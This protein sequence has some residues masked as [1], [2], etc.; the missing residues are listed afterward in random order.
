M[1]ITYSGRVTS[2]DGDSPTPARF[3][4]TA[5]VAVFTV[6][7]R[8]LR[9]ALVER[10]NPPFRGAWALPGGFVE[11]DE[12][13]EGAAVRELA[14]ETGLVG[15]GP[16][17]QFGAYGEPDR[18]PRMRVVTVAY[19]TAV[20]ASAKPE[21]GSDAAEARFVSVSESLTDPGNLAFDHHQILGDAVESLRS[22]LERTTVA[23]DFLP[24]EFTIGELRL[25]YEAALGRRLDPGN[26]HNKVI[27]IEGFV[28]PT[29]K[30]RRG[31]SG[32]PAHLYHPGPAAG[33]WS[34]TDQRGASARIAV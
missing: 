21:G 15:T 4:V 6:G 26:F 22:A 8:E 12:T 3:G 28:V 19:W 7:D 24:S 31:T 16:L 18:D 10:A 9:V 23:T 11:P 5:D 14:E 1:I 30:T 17:V 32:R 13:L 33:T 2:K 25:V 29:G 27:G 20:P 34:P